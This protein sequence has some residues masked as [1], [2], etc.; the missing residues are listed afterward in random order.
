MA[1]SRAARNEPAL[2]DNVHGAL[3]A[4]LLLVV[5]GAIGLSSATLL[6]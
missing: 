2:I 1:V 3:L 4:V 6:V 5:I